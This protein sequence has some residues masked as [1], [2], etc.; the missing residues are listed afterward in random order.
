M[1]ETGLTL[2]EVVE[3][4]EEDVGV[5]AR[6]EPLEVVLGHLTQLLPIDVLEQ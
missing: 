4:R 5:V 1:R 2:S 6:S 3:V